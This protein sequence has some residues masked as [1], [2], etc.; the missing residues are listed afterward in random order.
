MAQNVCI[1]LK[2]ILLSKGKHFSFCWSTPNS[3]W[4][5]HC[6]HFL[7]K[8]LQTLSL[9]KVWKC[10]EEIIWGKFEASSTKLRGDDSAWCSCVSSDSFCSGLSS[11]GCLHGKRLR[12]PE[13]VSPSGEEG[14]FASCPSGTKVRQICL[15]FSLWDWGFQSLGF[16]SCDTDP[17]CVQ[18]QSWPLRVIHVGLGG[19]WNTCTRE[20]CSLLLWR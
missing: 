14:R 18:N 17:L 12:K 5:Y 10:L 7:I 20:S 3:T 1:V 4:F 8:L 19:M 6:K 2:L 16:F 9:E 11:Q 13:I 15:Q